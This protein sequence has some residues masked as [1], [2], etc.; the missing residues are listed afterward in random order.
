VERWSGGVESRYAF[1]VILSRRRRTPRAHCAGIA[2]LLAT[3]TPPGAHAALA[4]PSPGAGRGEMFALSTREGGRARI[5]CARGDASGAGNG[6]AERSRGS[7]QAGGA[8]ESPVA[9]SAPASVMP[10]PSLRATASTALPPRPPSM[11][12]TTPLRPPQPT[13]AVRLVA[14]M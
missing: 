5:G 6:G 3:L 4:F 1:A 9:S 8:A 11:P 7:P 10:R 12:S 13:R 14:H 2:F